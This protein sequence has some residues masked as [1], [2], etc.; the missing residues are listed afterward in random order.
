MFLKLSTLLYIDSG[1]GSMIVQMI[2][3]GLASTLVFWSKIKATLINFITRFF[4][5]R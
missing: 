2:I 5:K 4:K 1:S 3:A